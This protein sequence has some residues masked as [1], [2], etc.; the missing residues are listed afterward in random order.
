M[1]DTEFDSQQEWM[2]RREWRGVEGQEDFSC[3][4]CNCLLQSKE[5]TQSKG[6]FIVPLRRMLIQAATIPFQVED[7]PLI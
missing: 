5:V 3:T 6:E 7:H 1:Q 4:R 2:K